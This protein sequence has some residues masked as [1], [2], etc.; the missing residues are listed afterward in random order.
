M[1]SPSLR[2]YNQ[3]SVLTLTSPDNTVV[4]GIVFVIIND[5][6]KL[7]HIPLPLV[8]LERPDVLGGTG[9]SGSMLDN[10]TMKPDDVRSASVETIPRGVGKD[11]ASL[12]MMSIVLIV[13]DL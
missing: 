8:L 10:Y 6:F 2:H 1:S 5:K 3:R 13:L 9:K 4:V 7:H 11:M 12:S